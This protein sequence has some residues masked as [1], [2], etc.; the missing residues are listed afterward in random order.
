MIKYRLGII[1]LSQ[2]VLYYGVYKS[3]GDSI[4]FFASCFV[5]YAML[6]IDYEQIKIRGKDHKNQVMKTLGSYGARISIVLT[7]I[8]LLG[9]IQILV[10]VP[11]DNEYYITITKIIPH[12]F[13][14]IPFTSYW[15]I[16]TTLI[17]I[18]A[19]AEKFKN[20]SIQIK[21]LPIKVIKQQNR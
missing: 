12:N 5:F 16:I 9:L 14:G 20:T 8:A 7:T 13:T 15:L 10:L 1:L 2:F 3:N 4:S 17:T 19:A 11:K 18:I 21:K 6:I